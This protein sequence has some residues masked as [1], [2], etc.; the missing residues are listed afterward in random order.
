MGDLNARCGEKHD[1]NDKSGNDDR[2]LNLD[3]DDISYNT[4]IPYRHS[5]DKTINTS[6]NKLIDICISSGLRIVNGRVR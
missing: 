5:M 1:F 3:I 6:G 2:F 4:D